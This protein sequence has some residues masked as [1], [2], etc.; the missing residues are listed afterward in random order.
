MI[1]HMK[2]FN[3]ENL[4]RSLG[5]VAMFMILIFHLYLPQANAQ[6]PA[7][8]QSGMVVVQFDSTRH[9]TAKLNWR[10]LEGLVRI[11][12]RYEIY[13]IERVY[14]F[15][16]HVEPT[17]VLWKNLMAL[18]R[19]YYVR[20]HSDADPVAVSV[21][22]LNVAGV[23][24]AEPVPINRMHMESQREI[25]D[26]NDPRFGSQSELRLLRIPEAWDEV[27]SESSTPKVVIAVIDGGG[28]WRH[29][30]LRANVWT[31]ENEIPE[32][33]IDDDNNGF[34]D[35]VHG[36]DFSDE[37]DTDN[38][39]TRDPTIG[40]SVHGTAA[41]GLAS[42]VTDNQIGIA[43]ASWNAS[44]MHINAA[45]PLGFGI[46][47][48]YEGILYAAMNGADIINASWGAIV[49]ANQ[50]VLFLDQTLELATDLGALVITSA[51]NGDLNNDLFR[52]YPARHPRVLS[53]GATEKETIRRAE[54]SNYGKLVDVFAP[55][56]SIISTGTE[57]GYTEVSGTSF[58]APL[59]AGIAALI[60]TKFSNMS[61]DELRETIRFSAE[62][63]DDQ[64]PED[65]HL[66]GRG[67]VNALAAVQKVE[68]P[69][70]RLKHWSLEDHDGNQ[71]IQS[72][73]LVRIK[74]VFVNYLADAS[75]VMVE[76]RESQPYSFVELLQ[77][78]TLTDDWKSGEEKEL[79]FEFQV[80]PDAPLNQR[81]RFFFHVKTGDTEDVADMLTFAVNRSFEVVYQGLNA[82]YTSTNGDH[83]NDNS[84]WDFTSV[85]GIEELDQWY[86]VSTNEGWLEQLN[87]GQ[88]NLTGIIPS[89]I[90]GLTELQVLYLP[91][92]DLT[93]LI[94]DGFTRLSELR[95]LR[96][97]DNSLSGSI[98]QELGN[99]SNLEWL[100][101]F[102]NSLTGS[103]PPSI[104]NLSNLKHLNL[105]SNSLSGPIPMELGSLSSLEW[106][107]LRDNFLTG[108]IPHEFG[109]LSNVSIIDLGK[110][111][112]S[113]LIPKEL[114]NLPKLSWLVIP[115]NSISGTIPGELGRITT[116]ELLDLEDNLL[117]GQIPIEL[118][119]LVA[120]K[121]LN[122][123][124]NTLSGAVPSELGNLLKL[125]SLYLS[126]NSLMGTLPRSLMKMENLQVLWFDGQELCA[127]Q[128]DEFQEWLQTI[129]DVI[130][131]SCGDLAFVSDVDDQNY[132]LGVPIHPL[133][134]PEVIGGTQPV[135]Y[136]LT[137]ALPVG[138]SF[139][140]STRTVFGT[141]MA[142]T[143]SPIEYIYS[144]TDVNGAKGSLTFEVSVYSPVNTEPED[145]PHTLQVIGNYPNPFQNETQLI[146]NLPWQANV[147]VELM[148]L[149][150]R[151]ILTIP[152]RSISAGWSKTINLSGATLPAGFYLYRLIANSSSGRFIEVG[153][154]VRTR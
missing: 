67:I 85:P 11:A 92:N 107:G 4:C 88:N 1:I 3:S 111:S 102:R 58:A 130:G 106:L 91:G 141:P 96:L 129:P 36:V 86:G 35:D 46:Q 109:A 119:N 146:F 150:G 114:A 33:G 52:T 116:L 104:G 53:V 128:D 113:G 80:F 110:N 135:E 7:A 74:T 12:S 152:E 100:S 105:E 89:E 147:Q 127:P 44:L 126:G 65:R 5:F 20:Y 94:P 149:I 2:L 62:S 45:H 87:L 73:D 144:A 82:L 32:N 90:V 64:N 124:A 95:G 93:G 112:L 19:T 24:Y 49:K 75:N 76:F 137:P 16:D 81:V 42:A 9:I 134:L 57:N 140:P 22:L 59:V 21:S 56:E 98:P 38:D 43:G 117:S 61:A 40:S 83:W 77:S 55:G 145:L 78:E 28:E 37:D 10:G 133:V 154:F 101:L 79:K 71:P 138:L 41:A 122:L 99:L 8:Y 131:R 84:N 51:G 39:P 66:L 54:F 23:V 139:L 132:K 136:S 97:G 48:G 103:I 108:S 69:A 63:I 18:R 26:P 120:L 121:Q 68:T 125:E 70:I 34:I 6:Q 25:V 148:D 60:K 118:G 29:E 17:P 50:E 143:D 72:G 153:R 142:T 31:N 30:D 15:L 27:K 13:E 14:P 151:H 115:E 47:Y 123:S